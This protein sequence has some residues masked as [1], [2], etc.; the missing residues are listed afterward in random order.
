[1]WG[2]GFRSGVPSLLSAQ[3]LYA[4]EW[5]RHA[6]A[7]LVE[8]WDS[9]SRTV[10]CVRPR[11]LLGGEWGIRTPEGLHPTN[12]PSW[13]HRPLGE[14]SWPTASPKKETTSYSV[15]DSRCGWCHRQLPRRE[16]RSSGSGA[17]SEPQCRRGV[18]SIVIRSAVMR[19]KPTDSNAH[20]GDLLTL[21]ENGGF[22]PPRACTQPTFQAGAIGH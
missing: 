17:A 14:F 3:T 8:S 5:S 1:M 2:R 18:Q 4:L 9:N 20:D 21:A 13:R 16:S 12:F 11:V 7:W 6:W 15:R 10:L 22:E 19:S